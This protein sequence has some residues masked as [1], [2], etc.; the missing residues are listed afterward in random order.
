MPVISGL[1]KQGKTLKTATG[2]WSRP[3]KRTFTYQ[4]KRCTGAGTR[5][6]VVT[7]A[8]R[9]GQKSKAAAKPVGPVIT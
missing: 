8:D 4:W 1:P 6:A 9:E 7:A 5:C 2:W 3:E